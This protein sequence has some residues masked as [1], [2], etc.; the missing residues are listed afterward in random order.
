MKPAIRLHVS[1]ITIDGENNT[2]CFVTNGVAAKAVY[3]YK[4]YQIYD[5]KSGSRGVRY[6]FEATGGDAAAPKYVQ[7]SDHGIAPGKAEHFHI[8]C[9]N[10]GFEALSQEM[11][12]WPT[13][14]PAG[15]SG[16]RS[17]RTCW[18]MKRKNTT[19]TSGCR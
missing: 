7:F 8:Y 10:D 16:E 15:M 12:H 1:Q 2:M 14:Y 18:S 11:D 5:Y 17:R 13:Y 3:S 6:F 19:S 4:G 9:G